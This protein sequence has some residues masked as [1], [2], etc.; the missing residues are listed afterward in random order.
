MNSYV[1]EAL[2]TDQNFDETAYLSANPDIAEAIRNGELDSGRIHFDV[3]GRREGRRLRFPSAIISDAKGRKRE[4][5]KPLLRTDMPYVETDNCYDFLTEELRSKFNII[6][7]EAVSSNGYDEFVLEIIQKY[8]DGLI[9]DCGAGKRPTYFENVVN[10]EIADYATT[11]VRGVGEVLPFA[12]NAF[13]AVISIAVLEHV[14]DPFLCAREIVRVLKPG[15]ELMCCVPFLQPLHGYPHHYYNMTPQGLENLFADRLIIDEVTVYDSILPIWSLTWIL[16][17]WVDGLQGETQ[18]DFMQMTIADLLENPT[19]DYLDR[20]FVKEL[21]K[22]KNFELASGT[23]VF[24]HKR[25]R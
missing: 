7:T 6:D 17:S 21:S 15:G 9:L 20:P 22:E 25:L 3:F 4:K 23:V 5:I 1:L 18:E 11:D 19:M 12:D 10:F 24:A 14:K 2:A 16:R 8:A 13:D